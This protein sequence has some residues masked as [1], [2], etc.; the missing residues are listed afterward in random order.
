MA[1]QGGLGQQ[2]DALG[3]DTSL[4]RQPLKLGMDN[5]GIH[6]DELSVHERF[7]CVVD[8]HAYVSASTHKSGGFRLETC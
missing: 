2:R 3:A 7:S 8:V 6:F 5:R 1:D 4:P